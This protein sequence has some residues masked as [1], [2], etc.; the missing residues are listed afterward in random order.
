MVDTNPNAPIKEPPWPTTGY[1]WYV[2]GVLTFAYIVSY[3]DR[4]MLI[5]M[6][7]PIK[8]DLNINDTQVSLLG[9]FAFAILFT[10][11]GIPLGR[12]ADSK[13]RRM[14]IMAG[15]T[16][17]SIMTAMCGLAKSFGQLFLARV[18]VGL[19]EASLTP[20][21]FSMI[22]DYFPPHRLGRA[23][24]V[25]MTGVPFGSGVAL[26]TGGA[27]IA[28]VAKLPQMELPILGVVYPWQLAFFCVALPG[29][30]VFALMTTVKE[31]FRRGRLHRE[32]ATGVPLREAMDFLKTHWRTYLPLFGGFSI[33]GLVMNAVV[34][35][36]PSL[37]IRTW[38]WGA[39]DIGYAFG[40]CLLLFGTSG[41]VC[42]GWVADL[43]RRRGYVDAALRVTI[44]VAALIGPVATLMPLMPTAELAL[45]PLAML[46]ALLFA[47]GALVPTAFQLVTPN[48]LRGQVTAVSLLTVN[49]I[50][51]GMGPT[52]VA[53]LTD[54]VFQDDLMLR[55]SLA[56]VVAVFSPLGAL[57]FW[58]GLKSYRDDVT[59]ALGEVTK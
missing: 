1:A 37:F 47:F 29:I 36:T 43:L 39:T 46:S 35:W 48:E 40:V 30:L 32:T 10:V 41:A 21:A 51:M 44:V 17:W 28:V 5:L 24:G 20:S 25:Y 38:G 34:L 53:L 19:G 6:I 27:V 50:G 59:A 22:A 31:P 42:G 26:L 11:M 54:Y 3:V 15:V 49:L 9:G 55:Y 45:V 2:V 8:R 33:L 56:I 18:G 12:L 13:S 52:A 14:L 4:Q 23:L 16:A 57:A 58:S 7:E